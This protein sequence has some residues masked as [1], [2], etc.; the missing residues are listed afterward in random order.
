MGTLCMRTM[1]RTVVLIGPG[2][3]VESQEKTSTE[4]AGGKKTT[5]VVYKYKHK[6]SSGLA[7]EAYCLVVSVFTW[8]LQ[9]RAR[10]NHNVDTRIHQRPCRISQRAPASLSSHRLDWKPSMCK[11][12]YESCPDHILRLAMCCSRMEYARRVGIGTMSQME[13]QPIPIL[14]SHR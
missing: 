11:G 6:W 4:H 9:T 7:G 5:T 12:H 10:S 14:D 3:K 2:L 13:A 1:R 8:R